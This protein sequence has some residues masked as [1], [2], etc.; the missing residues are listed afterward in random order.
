MPTVNRT[1]LNET[2]ARHRQEFERL[3]ADGGAD[4]GMIALVDALFALLE[5]VVMVVLEKTTRKDSRNSGL[6]SSQTPPDETAHGKPGAKGKGPRPT[7]AGSDHLR[8]VVETRDARVAECRA[9]GRDL[10]SAPCS[11]HERRT[12]VDIVFETRELHV[13]AE[14]KICPRC[15]AENRGR[16]PENMPGPLRYG[17]GIVAF[18]AQLLISQMVSLKRAAHLLKVLTGRLISEATLLAWILRLHDALADW[19]AAA[20]ERLLAMPVLHADETSMRID[21]KNHWLHDYGAGELTLKFV[22]P[23][24]GRAA[25]DDI[26]IIPRYGGVLVHDRWASYLGYDQCGHALCGSHLLRDLKFVMDVHGHA[27]ARRMHKLLREACREVAKRQDKALSERAFRA[28][29]KRY[30]TILTQGKKEL[31]E[32]PPRTGGRGRIAKSDAENL[33]EALKKYE[34]EVLRFARE[35]GVP[36]TNNRA[37]RDIRMAKV[38]QKVSGCFRTTQH[39]AAYCRISSYLQSM[40]HQGYNPLTAVQIALKGAA[41]RTLEELES[42]PKPLRGG[43]VVTLSAFKKLP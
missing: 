28:V 15:R 43:R 30:R 31:P 32:P 40:A 19:E 3:R 1:S 41:A 38:K 39:A 36:F 2:L 16:F 37:E 24:R 23:K 4:P 17:D 8:R 29:R 10:S 11:G 25:I 35:P 14:I 33:L 18:A 21:R 7:R 42:S 5:L 34:T 13:E 9:C 26:N 22:H 6:P 20:V 27:W 12:L